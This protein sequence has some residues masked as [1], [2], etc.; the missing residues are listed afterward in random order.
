MSVR[1]QASRDDVLVGNRSF[2]HQKKRRTL[3]R[4]FWFRYSRQPLQSARPYCIH[5]GGGRGGG[6]LLVW[7]W[8]GLVGL[9][10]GGLAGVIF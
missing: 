7:V 1:N 5:A 2:L 9:G 3:H 10:V 8:W 6:L 4:L